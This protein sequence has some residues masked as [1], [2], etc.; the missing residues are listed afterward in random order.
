MVK[1][2]SWWLEYSEG[3]D[4]EKQRE[5]IPGEQNIHKDTSDNKHDPWPVKGV[6]ERTELI[7]V[8]DAV[9]EK[10]MIHGGWNIQKEASNTHHHPGPVEDIIDKKDMTQC[11]W[12]RHDIPL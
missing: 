9:E 1:K 5:V 12:N 11:G 6:R 4:E 2:D 7:P 3:E 10:E 8:E